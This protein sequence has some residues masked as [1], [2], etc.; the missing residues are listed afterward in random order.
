MQP[1]SGKTRRGRGSVALA[2]IGVSLILVGL[3]TAWGLWSVAAIYREMAVSGRTVE[4]EMTGFEVAWVGSRASRREVYYPILEFPAADG[5]TVTTT[6]YT[7]I[8]PADYAPGGRVAVVHLAADP[9]RAMP[10][11]ALGHWPDGGAWAIGVFSLFCL[12][13]GGLLLRS[14]LVRR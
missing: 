14:G 8:A 9:Q 5:R 2:V 6:S 11:A 1:T 7:A 4:A 10:V 13:F 12:G 3:L